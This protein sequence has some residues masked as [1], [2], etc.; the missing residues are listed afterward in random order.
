MNTKKPPIIDQALH[1]RISA[2][3][4]K[5]LKDL[6]KKTGATPSGLVR[7]WIDEKTKKENNSK[8][9]NNITGG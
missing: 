4:L 6:A 1:I 3:S 8:N 7:L 5:R 2:V 9:N